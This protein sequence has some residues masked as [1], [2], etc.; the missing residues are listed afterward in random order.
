MTNGT[1][2]PPITSSTDQWL[3]LLYR[4]QKRTADILQSMKDTADAMAEEEFDDGTVE[5]REPEALGGPWY[6]LPDGTKVK[7][8][9]KA[10]EL[11]N[12]GLKEPES[13]K[14]GR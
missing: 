12:K 2:E 9:D 4:E 14:Q 5:L 1:P 8:Y 10:L 11:A 13:R 3:R 7:G 6:K